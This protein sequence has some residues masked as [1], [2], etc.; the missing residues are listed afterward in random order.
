MK[1]L[2]LRGGGTLLQKAPQRSYFI[3]KYF[4]KGHEVRVYH[5]GCDFFYG[6][7]YRKGRRY[8]L[9]QSILVYEPSQLNIFPSNRFSY[10]LNDFI[11]SILSFTYVL[12]EHFDPD[13][14][15]GEGF[16][17]GLAGV[18]LKKVLRKPLVYDYIDR[19]IE[20]VGQG[21][22]K[23]F[24]LIESKIPRVADLT[25]CAS[26]YL[27]EKA[28]YY[29]AKL[30]EVIPNGFDPAWLSTRAR[31]YEISDR[32]KI[33]LFV[34]QIGMSMILLQSA[35]FLSPDILL[36]I[37][38]SGVGEEKVK[39]FVKTCGLEGK[40]LLLGYVPHDQIPNLIM[41]S[42]VCVDT[43][44]VETSLKLIE[45]GV[46]GKPVVA[47]EG[48]VTRRFMEDREI[49]ISQRNP[50]KLADKIMRLIQNEENAKTMGENLKRKVITEYRWDLLSMKYASLLERF[51]KEV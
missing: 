20:I 33:V 44:G 18:M 16:W 26:Y 36:I 38:G 23:T 9:R 1:I 7:F 32:R 3:L 51:R 2:W 49:A 42:H 15:L 40:V 27:E 10:H 22:L 50:K 37:A 29:K 6:G 35:F 28:K 41:S 39:R 45:Y 46:F 13:I 5:F 24:A 11:P 48:P 47:F 21:P 12:A 8:R 17:G 31:R 30:T 34:G 4:P 14:I 19:Y 43:S 25:I